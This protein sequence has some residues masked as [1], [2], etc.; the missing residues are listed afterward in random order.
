MC[1][2]GLS[3]LLSNNW[4]TKYIGA[5]YKRKKIESLIKWDLVGIDVKAH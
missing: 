3:D 1:P 2:T 5:K 4:S